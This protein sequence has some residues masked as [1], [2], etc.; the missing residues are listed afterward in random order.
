[1]NNAGLIRNITPIRGFFLARLPRPPCLAAAHL[2]TSRRITTVSIAWSEN[3]FGAP[4]LPDGAG[5]PYGQ[6]LGA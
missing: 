3:F 1:M 6:G 5:L 4:R 2:E